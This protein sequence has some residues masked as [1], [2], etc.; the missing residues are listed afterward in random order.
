MEQDRQKD[1]D[2]VCRTCSGDGYAEGNPG[3]CPSCRGTGLDMD[4]QLAADDLVSQPAGA[5]R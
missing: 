2:P 4:A 5:G 3:P 1:P